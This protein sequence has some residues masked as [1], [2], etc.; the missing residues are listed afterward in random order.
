MTGKEKEE[1]FYVTYQSRVNLVR[2]PNVVSKHGAIVWRPDFLDTTTNIYYEVIGS[3]Q[4]FYR[5]KSSGHFDY[6][7]RHNLLL[8]LAIYI[9]PVYNK[10]GITSK[11][12]FTIVP[13]SE[14]LKL[15]TK[16]L[17]RRD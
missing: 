1:R 12:G 9:K 16:L 2:Q 17:E 5:H 7:L 15:T 13:Y 11:E 4:T 3:R 6:M 10:D 8:M 14:E